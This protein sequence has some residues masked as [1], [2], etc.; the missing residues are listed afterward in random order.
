MASGAMAVTA[1]TDITM[2]DGQTSA[3]HPWWNNANTDAYLGRAFNEDNETEPSTVHN[4]SWDLEG[5]YLNTTTSRLNLVSTFDPRSGL[6]DPDT[7]AVN[8]DDRDSGDLFISS[9]LLPDG[10]LFDDAAVVWF[11]DLDWANSTPA[12]VGYTLYAVDGTTVF[13]STGFDPRSSPWRADGGTSLGT[14]AATIS[15]ATVDDHGLLGNNGTASEHWIVSFNFQAIANAI[16]LGA[17]D[18]YSLHFTM[19]CGNDDLYGG[20]E[21]PFTPPVPEPASMALLGMGIL[22]F[23]MRKRFTL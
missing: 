9:T 17:G 21:N 8:R 22:G 11:L 4:D 7:G 16:G 6:P 18:T 19:S 13:T 1:G 10:G 15:S 23:A 2:Y 5:F 20:G 3:G 14:G 12:S